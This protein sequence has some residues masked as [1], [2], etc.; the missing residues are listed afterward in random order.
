MFRELTKDT[1]LLS[2]LTGMLLLCS[3]HR[4]IG[5]L[6]VIEELYVPL[7]NYRNNALMLVKQTTAYIH[8]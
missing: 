2:H 1:G 4:I 6:Q 3:E 5:L 8:D 7:C